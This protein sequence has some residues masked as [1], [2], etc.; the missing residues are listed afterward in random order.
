MLL[1]EQW[2]ALSHISF[3]CLTCVALAAI[4]K[5]DTCA[6]EEGSNN[7]DTEE[8]TPPDLP[9]EEQLRHGPG[10]SLREASDEDTAYETWKHLATTVVA[11]HF[12]SGKVA[13]RRQICK[14]K[15]SEAVTP[16]TLAFSVWS[17]LNNYELL[18]TGTATKREGK[19]NLVNSGAKSFGGV[20]KTGIEEFNKLYSA[21]EDDMR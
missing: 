1:Y 3:Y 4:E 12:P 7:K 11:A 16:A 18:T 19:W 8:E 10:Y 13:Y 2:H 17:V 14:K 20:S 5:A 15:L 9:T 6:S 21:M